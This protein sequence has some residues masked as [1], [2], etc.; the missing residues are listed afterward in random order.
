MGASS[1]SWFT[2]HCVVLLLQDGRFTSIATAAQLPEGNVRALYVDSKDTVWIGT[3]WG[4]SKY[5]LFCGLSF[6]GSIK[7]ENHPPNCK[8]LRESLSSGQGSRMSFPSSC[9]PACRFGPLFLIASP[10]P[11]GEGTV[12]SQFGKPVTSFARDMMDG[13]TKGKSVAS[14]VR[15]RQGCVDLFLWEIGCAEA[16]QTAKMTKRATAVK[17]LYER[18]D[19][20]AV[21]KTGMTKG[22]HTS[23]RHAPTADSGLSVDSDAIARRSSGKPSYHRADLLSVVYEDEAQIDSRT[24]LKENLG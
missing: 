13:S 16:G 17:W 22:G 2:H 4:L 15:F 10:V 24:A 5:E 8:A 12:S 19:R 1:A 9:S 23:N 7:K 6:V 21:G 11:A 20:H 18:R 3:D 14:F